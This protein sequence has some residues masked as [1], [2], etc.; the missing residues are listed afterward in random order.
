MPDRI[1][2]ICF[3]ST[4]GAVVDVFRYS[5]FMNDCPDGLL[6]REVSCRFDVGILVLI[7]SGKVINDKVAFELKA[8]HQ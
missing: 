5:D 8:E 7:F 4:H 1:L 6:R 3:E 2:H